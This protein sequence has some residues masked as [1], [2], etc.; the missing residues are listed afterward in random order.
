MK[1]ILLIIS[2]LL[3][4]KKGVCQ[5]KK[6]SNDIIYKQRTNQFLIKEDSLIKTFEYSLIEVNH[7]AI[8]ISDAFYNNASNELRL[9]G[10]VCYNSTTNC[11]GVPNV[12]IFI[13]ARDSNNILSKFQLVGKSQPNKNIDS[14]GDFTI[15]VKLKKGESIM[16]YMKYFYIEEFKLG[17]LFGER[18][19][20]TSCNQKKRKSYKPL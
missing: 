8:E 12:E 5:F 19:N 14:A 10:K 2:V 11:F 13:S 16:F 4:D 7:L 15:T 18:L 6:I 20:L 3:I 1:R 9:S 17:E